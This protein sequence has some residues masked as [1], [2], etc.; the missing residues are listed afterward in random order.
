VPAASLEVVAGDLVA[1]AVQTTL[2]VGL[3]VREGAVEWAVSVH[4]VAVPVVHRWLE[5]DEVKD[6]M[7]VA[8]LC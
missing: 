1:T 8:V 5:V 3:E 4:P 2:Q 6:Q 7:S